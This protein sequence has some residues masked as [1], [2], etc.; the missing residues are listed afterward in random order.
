MDAMYPGSISMQK[1]NWKATQEY[2]FIN[3]YKILQQAFIKQKIQKVIDVQKL[4]KG[5]YQDNLE[6]MQWM[7][8]F[9]DL[10]GNKPATYDPIARRKNAGP[11][12]ATTKPKQEKIAK[13]EP[14]PKSVVHKSPAPVKRPA[15]K[16]D[17]EKVRKEAEVYKLERDFYF[18]KLRN[19]ETLLDFHNSDE[20]PFIEKVKNILFATE[21][22]TV[23]INSNGDVIVNS[24]GDQF[25]E[26]N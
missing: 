24:E 18:N 9:Y 16:G 22:E 14:A 10:N 26:D 13:A 15:E 23:I 21:E 12:A 1:V 6:F 8:K 4:I 20:S 25:Q 7:K 11:P 17:L 19:I 3:N 5:K 2:E